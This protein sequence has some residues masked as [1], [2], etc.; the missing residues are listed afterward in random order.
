MPFFTSSFISYCTISPAS[1]ASLLFFHDWGWSVSGCLY[2]GPLDVSQRIPPCSRAKPRLNPLFPDGP[3]PRVN[4][5]V[6]YLVTLAPHVRSFFSEEPSPYGTDLKLFFDCSCRTRS[7][8]T[9]KCR[10]NPL[11]TDSLVLV[12]PFNPFKGKPDTRPAPPWRWHFLRFWF[13]PLVRARGGCG[14]RGAGPLPCG[15][16]GQASIIRSCRNC[17][18]GRW[19]SN[20]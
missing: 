8:F 12:C 14:F 15:Y 13:Q 5:I 1:A 11:P 16:L 10:S 4:G 18:T 6:H 9:W 3:S 19:V 20:R 2:R 17:S 7:G